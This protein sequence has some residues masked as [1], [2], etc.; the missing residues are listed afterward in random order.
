M[1]IIT[2]QPDFVNLK[3][4]QIVVHQHFMDKTLNRYWLLKSEE[5]FIE[6]V[7]KSL[8]VSY[9][10][11][12]DEFVNINHMVN[13]LILNRYQVPKGEATDFQMCM[14]LLFRLLNLKY[15]KIEV[16]CD[17]RELLYEFPTL[18]EKVNDKDR[19]LWKKMAFCM[20]RQTKL[21]DL[22]Y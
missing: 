10:L 20:E 13:A 11:D 6:K 4:K 19:P 1:N 21:F 22:N 17:D 12:G 7:T 3:I 18:S 8:N 14:A 2:R 15:L 5:E 9:G 16:I